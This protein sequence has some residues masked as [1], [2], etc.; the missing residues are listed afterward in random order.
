MQYP[1]VKNILKNN[2]IPIYNFETISKII[3]IILQK[4]F[5]K[6]INRWSKHQP[7]CVARSIK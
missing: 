7:L 1:P 6:K 2:Y 3:A 5:D 4:L